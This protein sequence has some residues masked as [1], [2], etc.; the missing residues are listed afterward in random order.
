VIAERAVSLNTR[1]AIFNCAI[2]SP[3]PEVAEGCSRE[4]RKSAHI[5]AI[6]CLT[7]YPT[8]EALARMMRLNAMEFLVIDCGDLPRA[9][10]IVKLVH[11]HSAHIEILAICQEDVKILSTLMRAGVRSYVRTDAVLAEL[12]EMLASSIENLLQK[13]QSSNTRGDIV[14]FLPSKPGSGASTVAAHTALAA[15]RSESKRVLLVDLDRDAPMQA[16]LNCLRPE[17]YLQEALINAE[18]LDGDMWSQIISRR[19]ALDILPADADG[20]TGEVNSHT[21]ALLAFIRRAYDLTCVDLPGPLDAAS[22]EVL[23]EA[24]R[25]YLVCTQELASVHIAMRKADR[26][27]RLGLCKEMRVVLNR[28]DP[29]HVMNAETVADLV[30]LPVELTVPNGYA[31]ARSTAEKGWTVDPSTSMGKSYSKLAQILL[32]HRIDIPRR[33]R[34]FLE[35]FSQPFARREG[36]PA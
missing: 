19:G 36:R 21:Q 29:D 10:E 7:D 28:Y 33:E 1:D 35:F 23:L 16:F 15:S 8:D 9:T 30:G 6:D 34:K 20:A 13:P 31:L 22:V 17:H 25:V 5:G 24:K 11:G 27:K 18:K 4:L 3:N 12:R 14:V 32:N 2:I 26:L